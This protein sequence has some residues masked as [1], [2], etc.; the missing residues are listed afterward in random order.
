MLSVEK[1]YSPRYIVFLHLYVKQNILFLES[2]FK[3]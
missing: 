2:A 1:Q 3:F